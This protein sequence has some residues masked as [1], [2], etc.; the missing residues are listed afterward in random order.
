MAQC[1]AERVPM[2]PSADEMGNILAKLP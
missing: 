1:L 2:Q